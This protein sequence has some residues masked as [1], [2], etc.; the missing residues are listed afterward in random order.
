VNYGFATNL[1]VISSTARELVCHLLI[2][3]YPSADDFEMDV[4]LY[5]YDL[6]KVCAFCRRVILD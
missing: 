2:S 3:E 5:V 1:D 4:Q 6:S